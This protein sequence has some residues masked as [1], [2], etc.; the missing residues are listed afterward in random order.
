MVVASAFVKNVRTIITNGLAFPA[1]KNH[2]SI[3]R[4]N[5]PLV[6]AIFENSLLYSAFWVCTKLAK[7]ID[8]I[9]DQAS[10]TLE[11]V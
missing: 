11:L 6:N 4:R 3:K 7:G 8:L 10:A 2:E 5:S 1:E 9:S